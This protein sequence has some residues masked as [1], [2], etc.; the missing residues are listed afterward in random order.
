MDNFDEKFENLSCRVNALKEK[1]ARKFVEFDN[2]VVQTHKADITNSKL[3]DKI[4][5]LEGFKIQIQKAQ[6]MQESY[7]KRLNILIHSL[8][9]DKSN[10][11]EKREDT[12][13]KFK[14]FLKTGLKID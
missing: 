4:G 13:Y 5:V 3:E 8:K 9:E 12:I 6:L 14:T 2:V 1:L 7:E 11:W 10:A